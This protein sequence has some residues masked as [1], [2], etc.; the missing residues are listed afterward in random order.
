VYVEFQHR[1]LVV[2]MAS[3]SVGVDYRQTIQGLHRLRLL[4]LCNLSVQN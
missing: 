2:A 1:A 3:S 4:P